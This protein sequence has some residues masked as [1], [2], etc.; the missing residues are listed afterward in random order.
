MVLTSG[1]PGAALGPR[2][3]NG[4][5][6]HV[7]FPLLHG[8]LWYAG[9]SVL[10]PVCVYG[11]DHLSDDQFRVAARRVR[12]SV[13]AAQTTA[14]LPFRYQNL[15]DYDHD[16]VLLPRHAPGRTGLDVHYST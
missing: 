11:A 7:L 8:T 16:L 9:M 12:D 5:L 1:S 15:G 4:Q 13:A 3:I 2:G 10:A 14:P 6:D